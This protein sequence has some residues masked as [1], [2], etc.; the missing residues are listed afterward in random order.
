MGSLAKPGDFA[1]L[2][3]DLGI[4]LAHARAV[5]KVEAGGV[6][7]VDGHVVVRFEPHVFRRESAA[8]ALGILGRRRPT[9][10]EIKKHGSIVL[11]PGMTEPTGADG[12]RRF[13]D[14]DR[15]FEQRQA[16]ERKALARAAGF[17]SEAAH[18]SA[19]FGIAQIMGFNH[20]VAGY[21]SAERMAEA[22]KAGGE[23]EQKVSFLRFVKDFH[24]E[25]LPALVSG[26]FETFARI[27][28]GDETGRYANRMRKAAG[29]EVA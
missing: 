16:E 29:R 19:S 2:I 18:R 13:S 12:R 1:R 27:Y 10:E 24:K 20:K 11:L 4:P 8:A 15:T 23:E 3:A 9:A 28:N 26:D 14:K 7:S 6:S 22:F 17:H 21:A 5:M 25:L